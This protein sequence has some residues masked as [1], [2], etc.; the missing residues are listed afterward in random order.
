MIY[1]LQKRCEIVGLYLTNNQTFNIFLDVETQIMHKLQNAIL[2]RS[3][4]LF[5]VMDLAAE[6]DW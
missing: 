4:V 6:L 1:F 3:E 5:S 2:E